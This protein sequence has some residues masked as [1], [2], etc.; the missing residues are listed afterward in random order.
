MRRESKSRRQ[1]VERE[2][3]VSV[4]NATRW[5]ETGEATPRLGGGPPAFRIKDIQ[6][7]KPGDAD[8]DR[9]WFSHPRPWETI[10]WLEIHPDPRHV[11]ILVILKRI[12]APV[13]LK[14]GRIRVW[15]WLRPGIAP[16][17]V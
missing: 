11:Q 2:R 10:E 8:W 13:S 15:R 5:R 6:D 7:P 16:K 12:G 3:L 9:E 14:D 17:F 4:L 1:Y